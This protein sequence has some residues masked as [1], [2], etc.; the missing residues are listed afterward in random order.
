ML[1]T[2]F[3]AREEIAHLVIALKCEACARVEVS[4]KAFPSCVVIGAANDEAPS[5][6]RVVPRP[7]RTS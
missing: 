5:A 1:H 6:L 3:Y 2:P 4:D 7:A